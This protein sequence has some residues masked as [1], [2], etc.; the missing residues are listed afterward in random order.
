MEDASNGLLALV[1]AGSAA[2]AAAAAA[3]AAAAGLP[4]SSPTHASNGSLFNQQD[5]SVERGGVAEGTSDAAVDATEA[6]NSTLTQ[7]A[8]SGFGAQLAGSGF[9]AQLAAVVAAAAASDT[10]QLGAK[11]AEV[12]VAVTIPHACCYD[13]FSCLLTQSR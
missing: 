1:M 9:G 6:L 10:H 11:L 8:G 5:V 13:D 4:G 3:A 12:I 2:D 7:L